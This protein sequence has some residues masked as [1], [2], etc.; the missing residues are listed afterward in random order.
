[1]RHGS[2]Q[3]AVAAFAASEDG[4]GT[5]CC[6]CHRGARHHPAGAVTGL[7]EQAVAGDACRSTNCGTGKP[8]GKSSARGRCE[9]TADDPVHRA[10]HRGEGSLSSRCHRFAERIELVAD[11]FH[12]GANRVEDRHLCE[13]DPDGFHNI[14]ERASSCPRTCTG[15]RHRRWCTRCRRS[16]RVTRNDLNNRANDGVG[17]RLLYDAAEGGG[18]EVANRLAC[19]TQFA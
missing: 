1:M 3:G 7:A 10:L 15:K 12:V 5:T 16:H 13:A 9:C 18:K 17:E 6:C 14:A 11:G 4:A 2:S 19:S 8:F